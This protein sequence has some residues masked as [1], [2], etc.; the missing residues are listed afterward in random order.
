MKAVVTGATGLLGH[1]LVKTL[2]SEGHEVHAI[3]RPN[4]PHADRLPK[5]PFVHIHKVDLSN[6]SDATRTLPDDVDAF[7]HLAWAGTSTSARNNEKLQADNISWTLDAVELAK[8]TGC[9]TFVGAGSQAEYGRVEGLVAPETPCQPE[10]AYGVAKLCAGRMSRLLCA[11]CGIRHI[12]AR[13]LSLYGPYD[14]L[15]TMISQLIISLLSGAEAL[16]LTPCEQVWDYLFADDAAKALSLIAQKGVDGSV[17]CVGGGVGRPLKDYVLAVRDVVRPDASLDIGAREY[18]SNQ[19]MHLC[20]DISSLRRD[21]GFEPSTLFGE[22]VRQTVEWMRT[23][24]GGT[25]A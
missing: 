15:D 20:A 14:S 13:I 11:D 22:G 7:F 9:H 10:T 18:A 12:W 3:V 8:A 5:K 16:P 21:T 1:A 23:R 24:M 19:V 2:L 25:Y 6:L 4:S 17:Y